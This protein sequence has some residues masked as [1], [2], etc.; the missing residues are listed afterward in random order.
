MIVLMFLIKVGFCV[1]EV[2][3][4]R[5][6]NRLH[7]LMQ[8]TMHI[9]L[10]TLGFFFFGWWI[11]FAFANGPGITGGLVSAPWALPWSELMAPHLGGP[12][13]SDALTADD[14]AYWS[15]LNGVFWGAFLLFSWT[16]AA[17]VSSATIERIRSNAFWILAVLI[18]C[19]LW[20]VGASWGWHPDG[21]MVQKLGYH[22]AYASGVIHAIA[23]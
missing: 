12:P 22:D 11:Y 15:R 1:Y 10:I 19:V 16:V 8:V 3:V 2:A 6:K 9:P 7:T 21:W 18:G 4:S 23:G 5:Y 13:A 20:V 17:I 14:T